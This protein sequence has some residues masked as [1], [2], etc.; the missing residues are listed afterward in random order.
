[1]SD[2]FARLEES[3]GLKPQ[4]R[5]YVFSEIIT[6]YVPPGVDLEDAASEHGQIWETIVKTFAEREDVKL[7]WCGR[8]LEVPEELKLIVGKSFSYHRD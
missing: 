4:P 6:F 3:L 8:L 5:G 1:M 7:I 2:A